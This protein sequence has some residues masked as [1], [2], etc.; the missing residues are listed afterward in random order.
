V[1]R[2]V[3]FL[4][5]DRFFPVSGHESVALDVVLARNLH[6]LDAVNI[7]EEADLRARSYFIDADAIANSP[8]PLFSALDVINKLRPD[9][10]WSLAGRSQNVAS[11]ITSSGRRTAR[12]NRFGE[13]PAT[14]DVWVNGKRIVFAIG[15]AMA[16]ARRNSGITSALPLHVQYVLSEIK[17]EHIAEMSYKDPA[18]MSVG[19]T[20]SNNALFIILKPGVG[21]SPGT[22]SYVIDDP[23]SNLGG[24]S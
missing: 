3:G 20:H 6:A 14:S 19:M 5:G 22:G 8:R 9:M 10:V 13:P 1:V 12:P 17:P 7:T 23:A 15:D 18:D 16:F 11:S 21:Y 4:R 24:G 2:K